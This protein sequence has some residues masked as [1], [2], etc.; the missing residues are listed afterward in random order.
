MCRFTDMDHTSST[1]VNSLSNMMTGAGDD[2]KKIIKEQ[3]WDM[4]DK[5]I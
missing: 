1:S 3:E 2:K 5:M 4:T